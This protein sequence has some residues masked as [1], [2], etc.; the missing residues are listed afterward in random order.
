MNWLDLLGLA[1][2]TLTTVSLLPQVVKAHCSRRTKDLSLAMFLF[3]STGLILWII[4]G[5]LNRAMPIV[6]ANVFTLSLTIYL[7]FLK[8]KHG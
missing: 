1:A 8:V 2:G 6:V 7:I 3:F 4:Y 5:L